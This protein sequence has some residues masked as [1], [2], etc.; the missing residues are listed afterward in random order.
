MLDLFVFPIPLTKYDIFNAS[1]TRS[2]ATS[3]VTSVLALHVSLGFTSNY[4][5]GH[6][7]TSKTRTHLGYCWSSIELTHSLLEKKLEKA[8]VF[9]FRLITVSISLRQFASFIGLLVSYRQALASSPLYFRGLRLC[10]NNFLILQVVGE[11]ITPLSADAL[12]DIHWWINCSSPIKPVSFAPV[13][14][15]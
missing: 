7:S 13:P 12:A 8:K 2:M 5:K 1:H 3:I 14:L 9:A 4:E 11:N 15:T 10:L 6:L